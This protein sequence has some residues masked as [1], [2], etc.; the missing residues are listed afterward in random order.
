M[1]KNFLFCLAFLVAFSCGIA[2]SFAEE[3]T[4]ESTGVSVLDAPDY[5]PDV[6]VYDRTKPKWALG[7]RAA[8]HK[9]PVEGALGSAF[10]IYGEYILPFQAVGVFSL[11]PHIGI[12][13]LYA[14]ETG[15][16]YPE[17]ENAIAGA[18]FR[19]QLKLVEG[20]WLVPTFAVEWEYYRIRETTLNQNQL[21]G[22][23]FGLS[24][25]LMLNLSF[26]DRE[27]AR[28][29][30]QSLGLVRSYFTFELRSANIDNELFTLT[31]NYWLFGLRMEFE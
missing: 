14:P 28:D 10:Q 7:L 18:A 20:Q 29:A 17:Y 2:P 15:I 19:Y 31:G 24:G 12:F 9:F 5:N 6:P 1:T 25:G 23:S 26:I 21:T 22:S 13:P 30:Y 4:I 11:G 8:V 27:T 16:P 3:E